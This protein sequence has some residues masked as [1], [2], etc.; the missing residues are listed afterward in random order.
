M[1]YDIKIVNNYEGQGR[2]EFDRINFL[3]KN[4][5]ALATK[6]LLLQI[7]GYSKVSTPA[8]LKK[9]LDMYFN[10][11]VGK[12]G[13]TILT[14][15][16]DNF[17]NIPTQLDLFTEKELLSEMTPISLVIQCFTDAIKEDGNTEY[18]DEP[19][20][21]DLLR[22]KRFFNNNE[23]LLHFANRGSIPEVEISVKDFDKI[24]RIHS[25]IPEPNKVVINGVVDE[26]RFTKKQVVLTTL[27]KQKVVVTLNN[28]QLALLKDHFGNAITLTGIAHYKPNGT[29]SHLVMENI[30]GIG[31]NKSLSRK[32]RKTTI[33]QQIAMQLREGKS[34]NPIDSIFGKWPGTETDEEFEMMLRD[35]D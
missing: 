29:M 26:M 13:N 16:T 4:I 10:E 12:D 9:Y 28:D 34:N 32:P 35:V 6:V 3:T 14:I 15:D 22:F 1:N 31:E 11:L 21:K 2:L 19:I 8:S 24:E 18:I 33:Q 30:G 7:F 5:K 20:V 23:E 27:D 17:K 25:T